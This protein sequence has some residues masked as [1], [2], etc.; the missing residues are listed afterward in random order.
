MGT[1]PPRSVGSTAERPGQTAAGRTVAA[2][3]RVAP[4]LRAGPVTLVQLLDLEA[5]RAGQ[6]DR[7]AGEVAAVGK[8]ALEGLDAAL[9]PHDLLVRSKA[10]LEEVEPP[11][12][13]E[14]ASDLSQCLRGL[15][16]G[17]EGKGAEH[18]VAT[19][20]GQRNG[21]AVETDP[22]D[23][24]PRLPDAGSSHPEHGGRGLDRQYP[25]DIGGV[26]GQVEARA[27]PDLDDGA[28]QPVRG[29]RAFGAQGLAATGDGHQTR[30]DLL[31]VEGH[32]GQATD[33]DQRRP[34]PTIRPAPGSSGRPGRSGHH[35]VAV[36]GR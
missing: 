12:G 11:A 17:A 34:V 20:V 5:G 8:P 32:A 33:A 14:D 9:E 22:F 36:R 30:D 15:R 3:V 6:G 27:E 28:G 35:Q 4:G 13:P 7:I 19:G 24:D 26:V 23:R 25:V 16:D 18:A 2:R 1:G 10:V 31:A 29:F 21:L